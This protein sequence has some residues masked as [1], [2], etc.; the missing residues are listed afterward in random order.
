LQALP[1]FQTGGAFVTHHPQ[2]LYAS[3]MFY[4]MMLQNVMLNLMFQQM[5]SQQQQMML[6]Q[7]Q[8]VT[9]FMAGQLFRLQNLQQS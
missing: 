4:L 7:Q 1:Q 6:F 3:M 9:Q 2:P 8:L 5:T